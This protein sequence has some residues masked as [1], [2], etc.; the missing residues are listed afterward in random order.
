MFLVGTIFF[1]NIRERC[2]VLSPGFENYRLSLL[3][4]WYICL[5]SDVSEA[6]T[7]SC[8][9]KCSLISKE[10]FC[11]TLWKSSVLIEL[12]YNYSSTRDKLLLR[13]LIRKISLEEQL[14]MTTFGFSKELVVTL[15]YY[16][17]NTKVW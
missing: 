3:H 9:A 13:Y 6:A 10:M 16:Y 7:K 2:L 1:K 12:L 8:S 15:K 11:K 14:L 17:E 4:I 5:N